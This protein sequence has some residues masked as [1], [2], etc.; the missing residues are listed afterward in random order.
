MGVL[1]DYMSLWNSHPDGHYSARN[2]YRAGVSSLDL[3]PL[4][5]TDRSRNLGPLLSAGSSFGWW[6]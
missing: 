1:T 4:A 5:T 3:A 2:A 6:P